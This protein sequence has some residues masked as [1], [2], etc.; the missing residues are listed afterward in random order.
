MD[1][2]TINNLFQLLYGSVIQQTRLADIASSQ[3][4]LDLTIALKS[5]M[6]TME[7][8]ESTLESLQ[9]IAEASEG[10]HTGE[11]ENGA[12]N[13]SQAHTEDARPEFDPENLPDNVFIF[14]NYSKRKN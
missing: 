2:V 10:E 1:E 6:I 9:A 5:N 11:E 14:N 13:G 12:Q 3:Y 8:I 4:V 7:D